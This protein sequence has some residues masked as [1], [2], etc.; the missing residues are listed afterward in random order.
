[1]ITKVKKG[2]F[3]FTRTCNTLHYHVKKNDRKN[4]I[5]EK[6][7]GVLTTQNNQGN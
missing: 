2:N 5:N 7:K 3:Y 4:Y 1:M 6:I